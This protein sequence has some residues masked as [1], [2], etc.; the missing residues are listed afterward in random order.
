MNEGNNQAFK[1]S[2]LELNGKTFTT[3]R[4]KAE[5]LAESFSNT[6]SDRNFSKSFQT[7]K[8]NFESNNQNEFSD[9]SD[10]DAKNN[11][12]NVPFTKSE[13]TSA[14]G[15]CKNSKS[16][17]K[18]NIVYEFLKE[19]PD[20]FINCLLK[21]YNEIWSK[22]CIPEAW[23]HAVIL[24]LRKPDKPASDPASYRPISLTSCLVKSWRN[25]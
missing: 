9:D 1:I 23:R 25:L 17:G 3:N 13:L 10:F 4:E 22:G 5:A 8:I 15:S 18:D 11:V 24:P 19:A 2:A 16:A 7:H 20:V 12:I 14:I 6:S 21:F